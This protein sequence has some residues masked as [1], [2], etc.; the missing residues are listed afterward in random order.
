M[1]RSRSQI[2]E[3]FDL[4]PCKALARIDPESEE[5]IVEA[6]PLFINSLRRMA[7]HV[8]IMYWSPASIARIMK[9]VAK[10][11][12]CVVPGVRRSAFKTATANRSLRSYGR[13]Q[14]GMSELFDAEADVINSRTYWSQ[15]N[16]VLKRKGEMVFGNE[17]VIEKITGRL[18]LVEAATIASKVYLRHMHVIRA[19][20]AS[21]CTPCAPLIAS[22]DYTQIACSLGS[23]RNKETARP[24]PPRRDPYSDDDEG[25][26][27]EEGWDFFDD[28]YG[29]RKHGTGTYGYIRESF[30]QEVAVRLGDARRDI[31]LDVKFWTFTNAGRFQP[32]KAYMEEL[33]NIDELSRVAE[34]EVAARAAAVQAPG[35]YGDCGA[36]GEPYALL[37]CELCEAVFY[38]D[39]KCLELD[40]RHEDECEAMQEEEDTDDSDDTDE[41]NGEEEDGANDG[42]DRQ[43]PSD[44]ESKEPS[45]KEN[46]TVD[47]PMR[48][49]DWQWSPV[50]S[51]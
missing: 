39:E 49:G 51:L 48:E 24:A 17:L 14:G 44:K 42:E 46:A 21:I 43:E 6:L 2:L 27:G 31:G 41:E 36:C 29:G 10:G 23:G 38:C 33:Y 45:D 34:E 13:S 12:E 16:E 11:F 47:T 15:P 8:D 7:F 9:Y 19:E 37:S 30:R 3:Y 50:V 22:H 32:M 20:Y 28:C 26:G 18:T 35:G 40:A 5:L 25:Y 1:H 4:A